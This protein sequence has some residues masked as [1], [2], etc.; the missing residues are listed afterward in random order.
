MNAELLT[1]ICAAILSLAASYIPGFSSWY[2]SLDGTRKRLLM[3][4]LLALTSL[5]CYALACAGMGELFSLE[6][7][8]GQ[9]GAL[10]L[11]RLFL[12]ALMSSQATFMIS[13]RGAL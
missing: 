11:L 6:L 2:A 4:A 10:S 1:S 5:G 8:C 3:L 12:A 13:K 7:K 9:P